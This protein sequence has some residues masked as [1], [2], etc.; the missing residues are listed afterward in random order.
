MTSRV[1]EAP[2]VSERPEWLHRCAEA[3]RATGRRPTLLVAVLGAV[4][5]AY[6]WWWITNARFLGGLD[7]DEAGSITTSLVFHRAMTEGPGHLIDAVFGTGAGPLVPLLSV[8]F[9]AVFGRSAT[10]PMFIQPVLVA[11]S[12]VAVAGSVKHLAGRGAAVV[13]GCATLTMPALITSSRTDQFSNGVGAAMC[14]GMWA[15]LTSRRLD[16]TWSAALFGAACAAMTISR[17]MSVSF[18][19]A[20]AV[21]AL[22]V[23]DLRRL[24]AWLNAGVA[25][26]VAVAVA[27]PWWWAQ[28]DYLSGYLS[29]SGYG[30]RSHFFG[31]S[32]LP[33]RVRDHLQY[34]SR[35]FRALLPIGIFIVIL[36]ALNAVHGL[37]REPRAWFTRNREL[38]AVWAAYAVGSAALLSSSNRGVWFSTPLDSILVIAVTTTG[39][40]VCR[41]ELLS[42]PRVVLAA[43]FASFLVSI[44]SLVE[45]E[46]L[47]GRFVLGAAIVVLLIRSTRPDR[48]VAGAVLSVCI[49]ATAASIALTGTSTSIGSIWRRQ[50][51]APIESYLA[52]AYENDADLASPDIATRRRAADRWATAE[53]EVNRRLADLEDDGSTG[54]GPPR[55]L[56]TGSR[57]LIDSNV[58]AVVRQLGG[59]P[60]SWM[61]SARTYG[62][63]DA[64]ILKT[65]TPTD[66]EGS[67]RIIAVIEGRAP[68]FVDDLGWHRLVVLAERTGWKAHDTVPLPDGG[69]VVLYTR[70]DSSRP[71]R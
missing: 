30:D 61:T 28:W 35:D 23:M 29:S 9:I 15:L 8:P 34:L 42:R 5:V 48:V 70:P 20:M 40:R 16:R 68:P 50:L 37:R 31:S 67:P 56:L 33:G 26:V 24:R 55:V 63:T 54:G 69:Q 60:E 17:S 1:G 44:A 10:S 13:A 58:L 52:T 22:L 4:F 39:A 14:L 6:Q 27:V 18:L 21:A 51:V 11:V 71:S 53:A 7:V 65:I 3:L 57:G 43:G 46:T 49:A 19:P 64:D 32:D 41:T 66:D 62:V 45:H 2:L 36:G 38:V 12:A 59:Q 47:I 25:A